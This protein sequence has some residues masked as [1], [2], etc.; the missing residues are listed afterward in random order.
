MTEV[1]E[2][3]PI[4]A[5]ISYSW[6]SPEHE[7]WV[8]DLAEQ[9]CNDGVDIQL[10]KWGLKEG[11]DKFSF[12]EK[13]I[14][15]PEIKKVII[16]SDR[17]YKEKADQRT[18]GVGTETQI[19]TPELYG[20]TEQNKFV[21]VTTQKDENGEAYIPT[22]YK[23]K[24]YIDLC[25]DDSYSKNYEQL[26][27]W[28]F[29]KPMHQKPSIGK[30]PAFLYDE[31]SISIGTKTYYTRCMNAI[32]DG[33]NNSLG[34]FDEYCNVVI[35]NLERFR[36]NFDGVTEENPAHEILYKNVTSLLTVRNE[37][38]EIFKAILNYSPI[39]EFIHRIHNFFERIYDYKNIT[40]YRYEQY[41]VENYGIFNYQL[42]LY[43]VSLFIRYER[44]TEL[45]DFLLQRFLLK[46]YNYNE[47]RNCSFVY[48]NLYN[49]D[50]LTQRNE[51]L[52]L[53]EISL[54]GHYL[55]GEWEHKTITHDEIIQAEL[56]LSIFSRV[57]L[58]D[59]LSR[60]WFPHNIGYL[61]LNIPDIFIKAESKSYLNKFAVLFTIHELKEFAQQENKPIDFGMGN[62]Y[63]ISKYINIDKLGTLN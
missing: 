55:R 35:E 24:I 52:S 6:S 48:F 19:I 44:F 3:Q 39:T 18:G 10:D 12:M 11:H 45:N 42:F 38:L 7:Q 25:D 1:T 51:Q 54:L 8:I 40:K 5:F 56:L 9:L 53:R 23:S 61:G 63:F 37:I 16:V 49:R 31:N 28:L 47:K 36:M 57:K 32:R 58:S 30:P 26:L 33:K 20:K 29:D 43:T 22:Y 2:I 46:D 15:D 59:N 17:I 13:M 34:C 4:K 50:L 41:K 14:T 21:I 62:Y 27:R 60:Q